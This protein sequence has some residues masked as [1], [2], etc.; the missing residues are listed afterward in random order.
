MFVDTNFII[1]VHGAHLWKSLS[2]RVTT[3]P[4]SCARCCPLSRTTIA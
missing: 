2:P 3:S 4:T 1:A